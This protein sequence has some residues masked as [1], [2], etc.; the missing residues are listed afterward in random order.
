[1]STD[2]PIA[3]P[4]LGDDRLRLRAI[5][6]QDVEAICQAVLASKAELRQWMPWCHDDYSRDDAIRFVDHART[7]LA[8]GD[9]CN[10]LIIGGE[11]ELV[12]GGC[13]LNRLDRLN[14]TANLGY[15]VRTDHTGRGVATSAGRL[16]AAFGFS[17][18][19][20]ERITI[21]AAVENHASQRVAQK[22]GAHFEG[23]ARGALR[24]HDR[25]H[26][27]ACFAL[28]PSDLRDAT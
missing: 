1:M 24:I 7:T 26:D 14:R 20:L 5:E 15:W 6:P 19:G 17:S 2:T 13:G 3:R 8:R 11:N 9:E 16:L 12:L 18:L 21:Q 23:I 10:L 25:Q 4:L 22:I 28:L 27:A